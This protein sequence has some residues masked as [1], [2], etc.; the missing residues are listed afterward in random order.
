MHY[1]VYFAYCVAL[2]YK[3]MCGSG[4]QEGDGGDTHGL[5]VEM[6]RVGA[7]LEF[8]NRLGWTKAILILKSKDR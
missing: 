6:P 2:M 5:D 4:F 1:Y 3:F 7:K 8:Q